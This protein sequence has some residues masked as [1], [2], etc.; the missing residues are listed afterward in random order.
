MLS[1]WNLDF[2]ITVRSVFW[3]Q[4]IRAALSGTTGSKKRV[5][6]SLSGRI[7]FFFVSTTCPELHSRSLPTTM[8][9]PLNPH[10]TRRLAA[11]GVLLAQMFVGSQAQALQTGQTYFAHGAQSV[12]AALMPE[13]G[14]AQLYGY[15]LYYEAASVL[16]ADGNKIAGLDAEAIAMAPRALYTWRPKL[17]GFKMTTGAFFTVLSSGLQAGDEEAFDTGPF[18]FGIEPLYLSRSFG[19]WHTMFG[20]TVYF[21]WGSYDE[22]SPVN[23][24][25]NRYGGALVANLTW[26]PTSR[27]DVSLAWGY[28][29]AG[30]NKDT[31]YRDGATTG[32][33]YGMGYRAFAARRWDFGLSGFYLLQ[34][35]DDHQSGH[36]I[37]DSRTRKFAI[38]P[39]IG[40]WLKP[41]AAVY[42]QV[43]N[44]VE[45]R[46]A[47]RGDYYWLMFA[48]PLPI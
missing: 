48:L 18:D 31:Q 13:A 21:P 33:T 20:T 26:T 14:H 17:W 44:E 40:Y 29:F 5:C 3:K 6:P 2:E 38:G 42:V 37:N 24:T 1:I 8:T 34:V 27:W 36:A 45:V 12:Y 16:D 46:N 4:W 19:N 47:P 30:R 10:Y 28:E 35:E 39:K 7:H 32:L 11:V 41:T 43:Q 25:L 23:S 9:F 22:N 15:A